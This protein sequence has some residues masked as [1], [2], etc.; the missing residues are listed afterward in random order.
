VVQRTDETEEEVCRTVSNSNWMIKSE[1]NPSDF[2]NK[3]I[4]TESMK[5]AIV[6]TVDSIPELCA[7]VG[8]GVILFETE[9]Q[10]IHWAVGVL[11]KIGLLHTHINGRFC[12]D[13]WIP[14]ESEAE[15]LEYFQNRL[16]DTEYFHVL[17]IQSQEFSS[18]DS[19]KCFA[20]GGEIPADQTACDQ[21][22]N[23]WMEQEFGQQS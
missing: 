15:A 8:R 10:A 17:P 13:D 14:F 1:E 3:H 21:C 20:C 7:A 19:S 5:F 12:D 22:H 23:E 18:P 4:A 16:S 9:R 6:N 11:A 2:E